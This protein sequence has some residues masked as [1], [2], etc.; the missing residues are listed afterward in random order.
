MEQ[1]E[2]EV[3]HIRSCFWGDW[4]LPEIAPNFPSVSTLVDA[5]RNAD[6]AE[7]MHRLGI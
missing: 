4:S 6:V 2:L 1:C 5:K 7:C 3:I